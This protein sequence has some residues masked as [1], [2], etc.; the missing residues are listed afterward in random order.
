MSG[1]SVHIEKL[2]KENFDT[3][4]LQMEA[5][6]VKNDFWSYVNGTVTRLENAEGAENNALIVA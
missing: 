5:I 1:H 3:W 2:S 4:K 6:L